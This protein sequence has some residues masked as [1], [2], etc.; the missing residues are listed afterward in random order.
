M[1]EAEGFADLQP[2]LNRMSKSGNWLEMATA[3]PME[4][5]EKIAIC[6]EPREDGRRLTNRFPSSVGRIGLASP[7]RLSAEASEQLVAGFR[8]V[9]PAG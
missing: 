9:E 1:L 2:E 3:V 8:S 5:V 7:Y 4:L 6:G